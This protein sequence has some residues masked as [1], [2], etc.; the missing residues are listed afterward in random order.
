MLTVRQLDNGRVSCVR[1][2]GRDVLETFRTVTAEDGLREAYES[3]LRLA[4][5]GGRQRSR[6]GGNPRERAGACGYARL[7]PTAEA[8]TACQAKN[9]ED[10]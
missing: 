5:P 6:A 7:A 2:E 8:R 9:H 10:P 1:E 3:R 4:A